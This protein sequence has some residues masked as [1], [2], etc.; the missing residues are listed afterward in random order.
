M[1]L[2]KIYKLKFGTFDEVL[3]ICILM[4]SLIVYFVYLTTLITCTCHTFDAEDD[5][6]FLFVFRVHRQIVTVFGSGIED[7]SEQKCC[8]RK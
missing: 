7:M 1:K 5:I 2:H 4:L 8:F 6:L 3:R